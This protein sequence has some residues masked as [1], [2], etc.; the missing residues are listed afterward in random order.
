[1]ILFT[2]VC[3]GPYT[4]LGL[5]MHAYSR[6]PFYTDSFVP[7]NSFGKEIIEGIEGSV[8]WF[9]VAPS[10]EHHQGNVLGMSG[11]KDKAIALTHALLRN[12]EFA[13]CVRLQTVDTSLIEDK[14]GLKRLADVKC[15][16]HGVEIHLI[17]RFW[18][19]W[20]VVVA[21]G[22]SKRKIG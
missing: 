20:E 9:S 21:Y 13:Q 3:S 1:M 14:V 4:T 6:V 18:R 12:V 8:D 15:F 17:T 5:V 2:R 11:L 10:H 19:D 22:F 16:L 7:R